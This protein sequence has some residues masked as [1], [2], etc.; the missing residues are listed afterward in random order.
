MNENSYNFNL[1][2]TIKNEFNL[3]KNLKNIKNKKQIFYIYKNYSKKKGFKCFNLNKK[4][5]IEK[6]DSIF[7]NKSVT[8]TKHFKKSNLNKDNNNVSLDNNVDNNN[9]NKKDNLNNSIKIKKNNKLIYINKLLIKQKNK[10]NNGVVLKKKRSS[11][12][13]GV[14]RN[15]NSWQV[16]L[17]LKNDKLYAGVFKTQE[18]AARIYDFISIKNK[19]I[20][21]N[22][23]FQ[24]NVHQIQ[25][26]S[27]A[28]IDYKAKNIEEIIDDLI[29]K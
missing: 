19:G 5:K 22:T 28:S 18:I 3:L 29:Q 21:A 15:G 12:Y 26:I 8:K 9:S 6:N 11:I 2:E 14:S 10:N 1:N 7:I 16:I 13:R 27:E 17:S 20:K 24:Y 4:Y 25:N 23:N